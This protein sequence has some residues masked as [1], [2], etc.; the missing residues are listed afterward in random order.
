M[1]LRL[2]ARTGRA[3]VFAYHFARVPPRVPSGG[4]GDRSRDLGAFH[5]AEIPYVFDH[6]EARDWPWQET[7][8]R[9]ADQMSSYW[10]NFAER[11]DPNGSRLPR[12]PRFDESTQQVMQFGDETTVGPVPDS[13][14]LAFWS[15]VEDSLRRADRP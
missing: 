11:G 10:A 8:R 14:K 7:D 15:A 3:P 6:L 12:W 5:T 1:S 9:L 4:E 2:Q 13:D